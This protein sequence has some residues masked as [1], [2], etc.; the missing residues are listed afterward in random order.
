V[1]AKLCIPD[2]VDVRKARSRAAFTPRKIAA[3]SDGTA[4]AHYSVE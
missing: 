1:A 3:C 4:I 2:F